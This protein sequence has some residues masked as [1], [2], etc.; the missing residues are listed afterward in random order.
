MQKGQAMNELLEIADFIKDQ[1]AAG[2]I[3]EMEQDLETAIGYA[4]R[5]GELLNDAEFAYTKKRES[6]LAELRVYAD[7]ETETTR[8]S[9]LDAG[10]AEEKRVWQNLRNMKSNL[11]AL[12]MSLMQRIRTHR[13]EREYGHGR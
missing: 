3:P 11:R 4:Y 7:D 12:Q 5:V 10:V 2:S 6:L 13:E 8:K 1:N 9:K